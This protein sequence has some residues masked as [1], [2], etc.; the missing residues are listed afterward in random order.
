MLGNRVSELDG[1]AAMSHDAIELKY[2]MQEVNG[3]R[4]KNVL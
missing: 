4:R 3:K 2:L 1:V